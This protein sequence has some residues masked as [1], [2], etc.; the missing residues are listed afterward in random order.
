MSDLSSVR[1][2]APFPVNIAQSI[3]TFLRKPVLTVGLV[4][5]ASL[6][7]LF[8]GTGAALPDAETT[9]FLDPIEILGTFLLFSLLTPY[10]IMCLLGGLRLNNC[11]HQQF[12]DRLPE[13]VSI[14]RYQL[15]RW[16]PVA[17]LVGVAFACLANITW[18]SMIFDP[19]DQDFLTSIMLVFGQILVW[20]VVFLVLFISGHECWIL[21]RLGRVVPIDLYRLD[22]LNGFGRVGLN[23][24]LMVVGALAITTVQ[25][26]D[27]EFR[28]VNYVNGLLVGIPGALFLVNLPI[29][30]LHLRLKTMKKLAIEEI[31]QAIAVAGRGLDIEQLE[32]LNAL[33][34]RR[35]FMKGLR[36][37]PMDWSTFSK[38]VL[39][40]FIPP[41][42]W[43]GAALVEFMLD[44]FLV[45]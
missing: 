20:L 35:E 8:L 36:S 28:A 18:E 11:T 14:E 32:S 22:E 31:D 43:I 2:L 42:A 1:V 34:D 39:Y 40:V 16:W 33:L 15:I 38:L 37:W 19:S 9:K 17:A 12:Q 26:I 5:L 4:L 24:L 25:S 30:S 3:L 29:W 6:L 41:L 21:G 45:G 44:S 27:Q 23:N 10:L 7:L 13:G